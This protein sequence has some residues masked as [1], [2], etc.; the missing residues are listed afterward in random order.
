MHWQ[1]VRTPNQFNGQ[2]MRL[3]F[4]RVNGYGAVKQDLNTVS[5]IRLTFHIYKA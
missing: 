5:E 3:S 4:S 1:P 2:L